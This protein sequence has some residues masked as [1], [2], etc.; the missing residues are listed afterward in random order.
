MSKLRAFFPYELNNRL[1]NDCLKEDTHVLL[2]F[3][4]PALSSKSTR[5]SRGHVHKLNT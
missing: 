2:A 1:G 5:I 4:F 3:K